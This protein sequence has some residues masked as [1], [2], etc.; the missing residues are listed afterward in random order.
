M[1]TSWY[2]TISQSPLTERDAYIA[3]HCPFPIHYRM[4]RVPPSVQDLLAATNES[5]NTIMWPD[6]ECS[7]SDR[8]RDSDRLE[9]FINKQKLRISG[10]SDSAVAQVAF[11]LCTL[12]NHSN[13]PTIIISDPSRTK[14]FDTSVFTAEQIQSF[15]EINA[16]RKCVLKGLKIS[17]EMSVLLASQLGQIDITLDRSNFKDGGRAFVRALENRSTSFGS[18]TVYSVNPFK[19][20]LQHRFYQLPLNNLC[21]YGHPL[22]E[23]LLAF[24]SKAEKVELNLAHKSGPWRVIE[25]I[26]IVPRKFTLIVGSNR[27]EIASVF[28]RASDNLTEMGLVFYYCTPRDRE[29]GD[30]VAAVKRNQN[31]EVLELGLLDRKWMS[32]HWDDL[33][34]AIVDHRRLRKMKVHWTAGERPDFRLVN[35]LKLLLNR[36][37]NII[38][39]FRN[40]EKDQRLVQLTKIVAFNRCFQGSTMLTGENESLR[41]A[42]LGVAIR[43][44]RHD[45]KRTNLLL[46]DHL[47]AMCILLGSTDSDESCPHSLEAIDEISSS[48]PLSM[49]ER[50]T[51]IADSAHGRKRKAEHSEN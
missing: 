51:F 23:N 40:H 11:T 37:R 39:E 32:S 45:A 20:R 21:I 24:K 7:V 1:D 47:D 19:R 43:E 38:I 35:G 2:E 41:M 29:Y 49:E 10:P 22:G 36:N 6:D 14:S 28:L 18:I 9:L 30:L 26:S 48:E 8:E 46:S 17:S 3:K 5:F 50:S 34:C 4:I 31:L 33:M 13:A 16:G 15:L 42:L 27:T 25:S 12:K 44:W